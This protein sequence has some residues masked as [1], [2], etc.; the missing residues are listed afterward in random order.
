MFGQGG[1]EGTG[2]AA[3]AA[4]HDVLC[5]GEAGGGQCAF[6]EGVAGADGCR[7]AEGEEFLDLGFGV[8]VVDGADFQV[9][10]AV[11][12]GWS[13]F[14]FLGADAE[15]DAWRFVLGQAQEAGCQDG[16][17]HV[18]GLQ[19]EGAGEGGGVGAGAGAEQGAEA[20]NDGGGFLAQG[21]GARG[22]DHALAGAD[23]EGVLEDAAEAGEVAAHG[24][25]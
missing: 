25:R 19:G 21:L 17:D 6:G 7:H 3:S 8:Y 14:Q 9:D 2:E 1:V 11:A 12:Q 16:A 4:D 22:R 20:A 15:G 5:R 24:G 18:G 10:A 23:Q 13:G